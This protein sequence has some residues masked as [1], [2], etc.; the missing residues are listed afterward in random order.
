MAIKL[1]F[2]ITPKINSAAYSIQ[3]SFGPIS[4]TEFNRGLTLSIP[5]PDNFSLKA[6]CSGKLQYNSTN[7]SFR[8]SDFKAPVEANSFEHVS[9]FVYQGVDIDF[10]KNYDDSDTDELLRREFDRWRHNDFSETYLAYLRHLRTELGHEPT[11]DDLFHQ[12]KEGIRSG[13]ISM[14]IFEDDVATGKEIGSVSNQITFIIE[15]TVPARDFFGE[16][17]VYDPASFWKTVHSQGLVRDEDNNFVQDFVNSLPSKFVVEIRDEYN[18]PITKPPEIGGLGLNSQNA[19]AIDIVLPDGTVINGLELIRGITILEL[20]GL[21]GIVVKSNIV[22]ENNEFFLWDSISEQSASPETLFML[23]NPPYHTIVHSI[24]PSDWFSEQKAEFTA[25]FPNNHA[26]RSLKRYTSENLVS[27]LIDG[28]NYYADL[29]MEIQRIQSSE[30]HHYLRMAGWSMDIGVEID[31]S[32]MRTLEFYLQKYKD[33]AALLLWNNSFPGYPEPTRRAFEFVGAQHALWD[34]KTK[35][36]RSAI[37]MKVVTIRNSNGL[38]AYSG[39]IDVW[40]D[41]LTDEKHEN[42]TTGSGLA[43]FSGQMGQHDVQLKVTGDAA[44]ELNLVLYQRWADQN[45]D[46]AVFWPPV[47]HEYAFVGPHLVQVARTAPNETDEVQGKTKLSFAK[48]GD[49]TIRDTLLQ[50]I[51]RAKEYVYIEDQYFSNQAIADALIDRLKNG[52]K[53]LIVVIPDVVW[54]FDWNNIPAWLST[55]NPTVLFDKSPKELAQKISQEDPNN[56]VNVR[57]CSLTNRHGQKIYVHSKTQIIDDVFV[58]CGSANLDILGLGVDPNQPTSQECNLM[59]IDQTVVSSGR[60]QFA[61]DLRAKLWSEHLN[62]DIRPIKAKDPLTA[63]RDY[64]QK[65]IGHIQFLNP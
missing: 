56:G 10:T 37:H 33:K 45:K 24:K 7:K 9:T 32:N 30:I 2:F 60:R 16:R 55:P 5:N 26:K 59:I 21:T 19:G 6:V 47:D 18:C 53:F 23:P 1:A 36:W 27:Y 52:L 34:D 50:A 42:S 38:I 31:Q 12:Y 25:D 51:S 4:A 28:R 62:V 3:R 15:T 64:W 49:F 17:N 48:D 46:D 8:L 58:S 54:E 63:F 40:P 41:R 13:L 11:R 43:G 20:P 61:R 44:D 57:F 22:G 29:T 35:G 65:P 14:Q 39:G